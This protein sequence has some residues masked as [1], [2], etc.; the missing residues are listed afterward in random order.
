M[1]RLSHSL[2]TVIYCREKRVRTSKELLCAENLSLHT[3]SLLHYLAMVK[4][5]VNAPWPSTLSIHPGK[6]ITGECGVLSLL[7]S[8]INF[9]LSLLV[10]L[11]RTSFFPMH[12]WH[13]NRTN[14]G[15]LAALVMKEQRKRKYCMRA[16]TMNGKRLQSS[17]AFFFINSLSGFLIALFSCYS[18]WKACQSS[19]SMTRIYTDLP[20]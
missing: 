7:V 3:F 16:L 11:R 17:T 15:C 10:L 4:H 14:E 9:Y 8:F 5:A 18:N 2:L 6:S 12:E 20:L 1:N 13:G 19:F